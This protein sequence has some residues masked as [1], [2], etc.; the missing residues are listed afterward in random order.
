[1]NLLVRA[2]VRLLRDEFFRLDVSYDHEYV[3]MEKNLR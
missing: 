2:P 3:V 1:M